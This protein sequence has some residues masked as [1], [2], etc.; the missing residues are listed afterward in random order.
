MR[1]CLGFHCPLNAADGRPPEYSVAWLRGHARRTAARL[2]AA[3]Q[4]RRASPA[5]L[6]CRHPHGTVLDWQHTA[7]C[8]PSYTDPL[9]APTWRNRLTASVLY[10]SGMPSEYPQRPRPACLPRQSIPVLAGIRNGMHTGWRTGMRIS[11]GSSYKRG[12]RFLLEHRYDQ[13]TLMP[14]RRY[15]GTLPGR[16]SLARSSARSVRGGVMLRQT[17]CSACGLRGAVGAVLVQRQPRFRVSAAATRAV[18]DR[19]AGV[20]LP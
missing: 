8:S 17:R 19:I 15:A 3:P 2:T 9:L 10:Q 4:S 6:T 13:Q 14:F 7:A 20:A 12:F 16:D 1:C 5:C 18:V 11:S